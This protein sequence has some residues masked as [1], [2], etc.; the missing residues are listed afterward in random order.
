MQGK[1]W[2]KALEPVKPDVTD[3]YF[4]VNPSKTPERRTYISIKTISLAEEFTSGL[5]NW[6]RK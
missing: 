3:N 6:Q 5:C 1:E 4:L 2:H